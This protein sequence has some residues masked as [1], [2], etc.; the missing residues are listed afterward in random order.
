[1]QLLAAGSLYHYVLRAPGC[2]LL[3]TPPVFPGPVSGWVCS[4]TPELGTRTFDCV[5]E[6]GIVCS[7]ICSCV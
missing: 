2:M 1:M 6:V 3:V 5:P 4:V 7:Y